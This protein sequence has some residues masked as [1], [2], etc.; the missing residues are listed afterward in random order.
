MSSDLD[1]SPLERRLLSRIQTG[2]PLVLDPYVALAAMV[3]A[4][5][6][7]CHATVLALRDRG[8]IRRIG[9]SFDATRMGYASLLVAAQIAPAQLEPVAAR[10]NEFCEVTHNY[11]R[12][13]AFNLWF[14]II[15]ATPARTEDILTAI[16]TLPGVQAMHAL[17]ALRTFKIH[18][19]FRFT[20]D[21]IRLPAIGEGNT[22]INFSEEDRRLIT[23]LC[24]DIGDSRRPFHQMAELVRIPPDDI[25]HSI[26]QYLA[27]G[28]MRRFGAILRHRLAGF[29]ANGMS[30]WNVSN[31]MVEQSAAAMVACEEVSHCYQRPRQPGWPYN[32]F[33]MIH[34]RTEQDCQA[35]A[36]RIADATLNRDYRLLFSLREFKKSSMVYFGG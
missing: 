32:L 23:A 15:A 12:D 7:A 29:H 24:G 20:E 4:K 16:Q 22:T 26:H 21:N 36:E 18:V 13:D 2:F 11:Q 3:D 14:T 1:F 27:S 33:A 31:D 9:G 30:V 35:A 10:V 6:D 5:A 28:V 19:D 17:P 8:V 25:L 34:A